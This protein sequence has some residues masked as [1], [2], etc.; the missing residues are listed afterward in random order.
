[1]INKKNVKINKAEQAAATQPPKRVSRKTM[2]RKRMIKRILSTFFAV[3]VAAGA[4]FAAMKLLFVVRTV[5]VKGSGIFT[6]KEIMDFVAIPQEEN[7]FKVKAEELEIKLV[8]EFT[9]I[10]SAQI[11]KRLPDRVEISLED[12]IESY[13]TEKENVYTVYSQSFKKLR[14][15]SEPPANAVWLGIEMENEEKLTT[16]KKMLELFDKYNLENITKISVADEM[17]IS[18]VYDERIE[19][20]FGTVLDIDYKIKM[21][22]KVLDEKIPA[23]EKGFIDATEGGE[24]VYKRQ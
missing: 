18:A 1:M 15:S 12:S 24:V 17:T 4:I 8:E 19:I 5:E 20:S 6:A 16:V 14:T 3:A 21:C 2:R 13:F 10:D 9:Y 11:V 23:G 22:K 7:I